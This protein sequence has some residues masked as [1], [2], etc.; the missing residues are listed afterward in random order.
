[1]MTVIL[2]IGTDVSMETAARNLK[3]NTMKTEAEVGT[4]RSVFINKTI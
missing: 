4:E 3:I 1:M 2:E